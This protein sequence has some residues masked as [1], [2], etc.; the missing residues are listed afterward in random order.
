MTYRHS[1]CISISGRLFA[2]RTK[3]VGQRLP[4]RR[5]RLQGISHDVSHT[6]EFMDHSRIDLQIGGNAGGAEPCCVVAS[7]IHQ[8]IK[9]GQHDERRR[10]S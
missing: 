3:S 7:L 6:Q 5:P 8:G 10:Q 1:R 2:G 4:D 9:F